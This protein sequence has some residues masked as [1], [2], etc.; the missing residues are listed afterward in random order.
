MDF[1]DVR[2]ML[3]KGEQV[4]MEAENLRNRLRRRLA[5]DH[6]RRID[7]IHNQLEDIDDAMKPIRSHMGRLQWHD[8][9]EDIEAILPEVSSALQA[10]RRQLKKM[11]PR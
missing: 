2:G 4:A 9:P 1:D 6:P 11:L 7:A 5:I 3:I 8:Y 10:Q